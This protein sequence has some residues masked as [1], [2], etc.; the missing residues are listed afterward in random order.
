MFT[1]DSALQHTC[2]VFREQAAHGDITAAECDLLIDGAV[3]L[4]ANIEELVQDSRADGPPAWPGT[5]RA[6][7]LRVPAASSAR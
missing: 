7:A 6:P 4:A 2:A 3:L 1:V 5:G